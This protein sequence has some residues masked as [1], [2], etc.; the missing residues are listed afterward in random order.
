MCDCR[1]EEKNESLS[2]TA[3]MSDL[4]CCTG[5]NSVERE[6]E[7]RGYT[8]THTHTHNNISES[9]SSLLQGLGHWQ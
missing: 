9:L 8:H 4:V 5:N 1:T 3:E 7:Y 6:Y 2:I